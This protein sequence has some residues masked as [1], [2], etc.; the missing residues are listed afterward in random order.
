MLGSD[1]GLAGELIELKEWEISIETVGQII[2]TL[3]ND[4]IAYQRLSGCVPSAAA[5]F[6][7]DAMGDKY[8]E[9]YRELLA[10]PERDAT[11]SNSTMRSI[12]IHS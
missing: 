10:P 1:D 3:A 7:T 4:P 12:K 8:E 9:V 2:V 11:D 5:K 6:D